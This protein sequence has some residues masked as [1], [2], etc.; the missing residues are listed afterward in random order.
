MFQ[1][2]QI[3]QINYLVV[4]KGDVVAGF[5]TMYSAKRYAESLTLSPI[6][7]VRHDG[8]VLLDTIDV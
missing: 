3:N 4:V 2:M 7:I 8:V 6:V 5:D 1:R